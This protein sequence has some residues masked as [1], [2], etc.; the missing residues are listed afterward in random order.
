MERRSRRPCSGFGLLSMKSGA[1]AHAPGAILVEGEADIVEHVG[2]VGLDGEQVVGAAV[3]QIG[4]ERALGEQG[5]GGDGA[6]C[7]VG[8]RLERGE[9]GADLVGAFLAFVEVGSHAVFF[10][11]SKGALESWPT[12]PST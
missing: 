10:F 4:G 6:P 12:M 7:D 5:I 9:D 11:C 1:R 8:D 2:L 3:E